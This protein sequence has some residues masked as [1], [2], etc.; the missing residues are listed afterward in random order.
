MGKIVSPAGEQVFEMHA[1][2]TDNEGVVMVSSMGVWDA[3]VHLSYKEIAA[4]LLK[5]GAL[6]AILKIP[7]LLLKGL[8]K[9]RKE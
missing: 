8:F 9:R 2:K 5:P 6:L 4:S 3:E 1:I 7:F